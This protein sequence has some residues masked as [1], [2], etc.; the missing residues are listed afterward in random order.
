MENCWQYR[1]HEGWS[2]SPKSSEMVDRS[3][4]K[5]AKT[6]WGRQHGSRKQIHTWLLL[7]PAPEGGRR[8]VLAYASIRAHVFQRWTLALFTHKKYVSQELELLPSK[9]LYKQYVI[10]LFFSLKGS[11]LL[12]VYSVYVIIAF[13]SILRQLLSWI[14]FAN[15]KKLLQGND[16]IS[17][18][19]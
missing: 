11:C 16:V 9:K 5:L 4:W 12:L 17:L 1:W 6:H 7:P 10:K 14:L 13:L 18:Q 3:L 2:L 19:I 8:R 15:I